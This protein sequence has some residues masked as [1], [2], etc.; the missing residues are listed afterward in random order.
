MKQGYKFLAKHLPILTCCS[1][2]TTAMGVVAMKLGYNA[3]TS[4]LQPLGVCT[5]IFALMCAFSIGYAAY[6]SKKVPDIHLAKVKKKSA[7]LK[8][9]SIVSFVMIFFMFSLE[10]RKLILASYSGSIPEFFTTWRV[11]K[12]IFAFP[13]S[14]HFF[15]MALPSKIKR[16]KR[17]KIPKFIN[18]IATLG[19][20]FWSI[21]GL[22]SAYFYS[23]MSIKNILKIWQLIVYLAFILFFLFEAK[24]DHLN[25]GKSTSRGFIFAGC[26]AF[27]LSCAFSLTSTLCMVFRIIPTESKIVFSATEVFT[28]F[29]I[30]LYAFSKIFAYM[31]TAKIV[32]YNNDHNP[33]SSKFSN[34]HRH[35]SSSMIKN[36]SNAEIS[37]DD[38]ANLNEI[39]S[40]EINS[41]ENNSNVNESSENK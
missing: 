8:I 28:S 21:F 23:Q 6:I 38:N 18:Y 7:F 40:S 24:F 36:D 19:V 10:T 25:K 41:S 2:A 9:S 33:S 30:G 27:I 39:N 17:I 13:A 1:L 12:Y 37:S 20:I 29:A 31:H 4:W 11:L 22:L 5:I 34:H 3:V 16:K 32:A 26:L 14:V 15:L 35:S